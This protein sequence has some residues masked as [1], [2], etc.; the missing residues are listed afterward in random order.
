LEGGEL[1]C[2]ECGA[3]FSG[4]EEGVSDPKYEKEAIVTPTYPIAETDDAISTPTYP[5]VEAP[6]DVQ[7]EDMSEL[8]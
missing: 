3:D 5:P 1:F 2:P 8:T 4:G 6:I 7:S